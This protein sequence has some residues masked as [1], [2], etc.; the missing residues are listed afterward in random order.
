MAKINNIIKQSSPKKRFELTE[1]QL[2]VLKTS[3]KATLAVVGIAGFIMLSAVAP[4]LFV[5]LDKI[6]RSHKKRIKT[7]EDRIKLEQRVTQSLYY[8]KKQRF[9]ELIQQDDDYLVR[10]TR[11]GQKTLKKFQFDS[12]AIDSTGR[13]WDGNW[14]V[15]LADIPS[16]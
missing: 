4:N 2:K 3:S 12:L 13:Q 1:Q 14:W 15:A 6:S 5:A 7:R 11:K 8:L 16:E 9:I 10:L